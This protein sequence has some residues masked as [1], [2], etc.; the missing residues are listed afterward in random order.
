MKNKIVN[1]RDNLF[2]GMEMLLDPESGFTPDHAHALAAMGKVIVESAK[3]EL[4][5]AKLLGGEKLS[6]D[7]I[8]VNNHRALRAKDF[9]EHEEHQDTPPIKE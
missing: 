5:A 7:F 9:D 4:Q 2:L 3:T 1:L 8:E 6:N